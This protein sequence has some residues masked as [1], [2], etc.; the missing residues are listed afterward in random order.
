MP[1]RGRT[2]SLIGSTHGAVSFHVTGRKTK[3]RR[4]KEDMKKRTTCV[5]VA[6]PGRM[7]PGKGYCTDCFGN[8][9]NETQRKLDSL[10]EKLLSLGD[11]N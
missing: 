5:R 3:C 7:G 6:K 9:L 2:P 4:C 10:R 8:V 1:P 11:G